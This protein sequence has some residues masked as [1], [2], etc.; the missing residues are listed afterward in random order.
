[1]ITMVKKGDTNAEG[2][3]LRADLGIKAFAPQVVVL[4]DIKFI[5]T[6]A[7]SHLHQTP[8]SVLESVALEQSSGRYS[9]VDCVI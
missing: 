7:L 2:L 6:D 1:M 9:T 8:E 4:F 3:G 5:D